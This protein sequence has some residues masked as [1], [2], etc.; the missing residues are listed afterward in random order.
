MSL[1]VFAN[2]DFLISLKYLAPHRDLQ[3]LDNKQINKFKFNQFADS[4][5]HAVKINSSAYS[6]YKLVHNYIILN[7]YL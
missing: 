1:A 4:V 7:K 2:F 3:K 6:A 5:I